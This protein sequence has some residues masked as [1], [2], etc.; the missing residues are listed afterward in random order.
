MTDLIVVFLSAFLAATIIPFYSEVVVVSELLLNPHLWLWIWLLASLGNTLGAVVNW[1]IGRYLLH[2]QD[3]RWFPV[4]AEQLKRG[5]QWFQKYGIWSLLLA[6][7]PVGG[8]AL[9]VIAG[10]MRVRL[11]VF[12]I[13]TFLGKGTRYLVVVYLTDVTLN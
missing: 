6:W 11:W 8:D 4:K 3:R 5:Q 7:A 2:Y 1:V 13:L 10:M 9:T 12:F